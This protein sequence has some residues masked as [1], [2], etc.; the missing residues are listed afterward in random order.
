MPARAANLNLESNEMKKLT[1]LATAALLAAPAFA[2]QNTNADPF[3]A[4][5]GASDGTA[6][7]A[8]GAVAGGIAASIAVI[9]IA[10]ASTSSSTSTIK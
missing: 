7:A 3:A 4:T 10:G 1:V 2:D 5:Q 6:I 8:P 9:A